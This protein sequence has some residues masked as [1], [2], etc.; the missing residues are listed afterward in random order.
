[1]Q[2]L[3]TDHMDVI[4]FTSMDT[5]RNHQNSQINAVKYEG[6]DST[7][8]IKCAKKFLCTQVSMNLSLQTFK[9]HN[10]GSC[11]IYGHN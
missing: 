11:H 3:R 10:S 4:A 1:M 6:H 7:T 8:F 2:A 9:K 5:D